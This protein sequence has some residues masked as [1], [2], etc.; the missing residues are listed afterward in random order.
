VQINN[1]PLASTLHT[2]NTHYL[3][4]AQAA[5]NKMKLPGRV[6][7]FIVDD[8]YMV[9]EGIKALLQGNANIEFLGSA[10]TEEACMLF[11]KQE[12]PDIILMDINLSGGSGI[13]LC[14]KV[15]QT[16]P[17][18]FVIGLSTFN[19]IS[20]IKNMMDNGASGYLL[21]NAGYDEII[22]ALGKVMIGQ[23]YMSLEAS[24]AIRQSAANEMPVLT[25][26]EKEVLVLIAD[27]CTN[28]EI[29]EQLFIGVSTVD[30]HRKNLLLKMNARNTASLVK[31]AVD[32]K[33][34]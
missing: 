1:N 11:L 29:A 9:V 7:L 10:A 18:V 31:I 17:S 30:T 23:E 12:L 6:R 26:R 27:G 24:Q 32:N 25:R 33:L 19:Q 15:R 3:T 5:M 28:G 13:D 8:H 22:E 14:K 16:Y 20:F 34:I 4:R 21:K 2:P